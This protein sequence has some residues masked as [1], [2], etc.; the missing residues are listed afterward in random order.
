VLA[1]IVSRDDLR[2]HILAAASLSY[3]LVFPGGD[4]SHA[5]RPHLVGIP[6][7]IELR[8]G[9]GAGLRRRSWVAAR[10]WAEPRLIVAGGSRR[11]V[12]AAGAALELRLALSPGGESPTAVLVR[13]EVTTG[14]LTWNGTA[15]EALLA[16]GV[17]F[18]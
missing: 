3:G 14:T 8:A 18:R 15:T 5:G 11:A 10:A 12:V 1:P 7:A 17:A 4:A 6:I 13:G 16:A 2:D 9:L